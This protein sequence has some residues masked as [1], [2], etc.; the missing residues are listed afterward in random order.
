MTNNYKQQPPRILKINGVFTTSLRKITNEC[1]IFFVN[2]IGKLR[3]KFW[4]NCKVKAI[5]ILEFL[6][7]RSQKRVIFTKIDRQGVKKLLKQAKA[8][9]SLGNDIV[10]MKT[11]KKL[12]ACIEIYIEHL[13]NS[14][15][16]SEVY[17]NIFKVSK[18]TPELKP[19]K[20]ANIIDLYWPINN[21]LALEKLVE[22]HLKNCII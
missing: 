21:L 15:I 9:N 3:D 6:I 17:P 19:E 13:I 4:H 16:E 5:G 2:K 11:I 1:N 12:G 20:L 18:N 10:S 8:S 14:I 7:P 22:Q